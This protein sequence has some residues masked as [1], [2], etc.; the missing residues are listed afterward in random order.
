M[1]VCVYHSECVCVCV[2]VCVS[3]CVHVHVHDSLGLG[4]GPLGDDGCHG[5]ARSMTL[6][7]SHQC[8]IKSYCNA[9]GEYWKWYTVG[10]LCGGKVIQ[11]VIAE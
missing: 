10:T 5:K 11:A 4:I 8:H 6:S 3:R 1:C 2:S 7:L 9:C